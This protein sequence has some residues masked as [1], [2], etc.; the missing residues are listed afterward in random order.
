MKYSP[1]KWVKLLPV[2]R[3]LSKGEVKVEKGKPVYRLLY[4]LE[5][6][7]LVIRVYDGRNYAR[8]RAVRNISM[9]EKAIPIMLFVWEIRRRGRRIR[10]K[11]LD[12]VDRVERAYELAVDVW[13]RGKMLKLVADGRYESI[14][15]RRPATY[16]V[17][18]RD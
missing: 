7:G 10:W 17:V 6:M 1:Y 8:F 13:K 11:G 4:D 2:I 3:L 16:G 5:E 15:S 14:V 12:L 18:L 9:V